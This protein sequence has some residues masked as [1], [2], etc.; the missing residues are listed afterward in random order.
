M[1]GY[2]GMLQTKAVP[3]FVP[4]AKG[5]KIEWH[6]FVDQYGNKYPDG[7]PYNA[8]KPTEGTLTYPT[9][10]VIEPLLPLPSRL[11]RVNRINNRHL[12]DGAA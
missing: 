4:Y 9:A 11:P 7:T 3:P 8:G 2:T 10:D 1:K 6:D 5:V 12:R